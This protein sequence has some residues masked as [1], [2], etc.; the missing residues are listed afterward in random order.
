MIHLIARSLLIGI[1]Y[2]GASVRGLAASEGTSEKSIE[3]RL[4]RARPP[5]R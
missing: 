3:S 2:A 4:T 1:Y 5:A